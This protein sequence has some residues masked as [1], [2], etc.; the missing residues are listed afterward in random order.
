MCRV[1]YCYEPCPETE[2]NL[3]LMR[4]LHELHLEPPVYGSRKLTVVLGREGAVGNRKRVVR[5]LR[6]MGIEGI[7]AKP[8]TSLPEPGHQIYPH[9]LR[10]LE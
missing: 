10:D 3:A 1:S 2:E 7:Y 5:L 8:R 6:R 4:R 9:L